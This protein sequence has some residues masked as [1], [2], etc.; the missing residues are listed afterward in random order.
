M[1]SALC[2]H[3]VDFL[4]LFFIVDH[5]PVPLLEQSADKHRVVTFTNVYLVAWHQIFIL[6]L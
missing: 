6:I 1:L 5:P 2:P 4:N 3:Q